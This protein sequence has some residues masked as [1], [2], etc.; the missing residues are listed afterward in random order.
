VSV[1]ERLE[2]AERRGRPDAIVFR[3]LFF[4]CLLFVAFVVLVVFV[5]REP[6]G[7]SPRLLEI[8]KLRR[9]VGCVFTGPGERRLPLKDGVFDPYAFVRRG[10]ITRERY[11]VF[12]SARSGTGPTDEE[13]ERGDYTNFPWE[14]YRGDGELPGDRIPILW[15][16]EPD[17]RGGR[18]VAFAD[19]SA[20]LVAA[21]RFESCWILI[22]RPAL[23]CVVKPVAD[24]GRIP[25]KDGQFDPYAFVR[26]GLVPASLLRS[27]SGEG[28][29][30]EEIARGD[31]TN[32]RWERY[33]GDGTLEGP[34]FPLLWSKAPDRRG[35][36]L[37]GYSDG[38][39]GVLP[40]ER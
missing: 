10:E 21:D 11:D 28:P 39:C 14:R 16:K 1:R 33:R 18:V 2:R 23:R 5:F 37:V 30:D 32:F 36:Q 12:R 9:I 34:P 17:K 7:F 35:N 25:M 8:D 22:E 40:E 29:T 6:C 19:G 31:Y 3:I 15:E 13:I 38:T 4:G 26:E 27:A 24:T 20:E